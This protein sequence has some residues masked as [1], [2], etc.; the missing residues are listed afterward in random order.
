MT[1]LSRLGVFLGTFA[2]G[3]FRA[4]DLSRVSTKHMRNFRDREISRQRTFAPKYRKARF[5]F[6]PC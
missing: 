6:L 4:R 5:L 2:P 3:N 1:E